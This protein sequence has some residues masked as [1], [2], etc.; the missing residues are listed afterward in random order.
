M[1]LWIKIDTNMLGDER[2]E[3]LIAGHGMKGLGTYLMIRLKMEFLANDQC[4][5]HMLIEACRS[6][7]RRNLLEDIISNYN[8]FFVDENQLVSVNNT[9][10][11]ACV[12]ALVPA[13][14]PMHTPDPV[15]EGAPEGVPAHGSS[16]RHDSIE[17]NR[18]ENSFIKELLHD[19][20][21]QWAETV[22]MQSGYGL[23]LRKYWAQAVEQFNQHVIAYDKLHEVQTTRDTRYYFNSFVKTSVKSGQNLRQYLQQLEND[24]RA[25]DEV[26]QNMVYNFATESFQEI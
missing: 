23:L 16:R 25:S 4:Q 22:C 3:R 19:Q 18:I 13:H 9:G 6:H 1:K 5:K 8:L 20:H 12:P 10:S 26:K 21:T 15:P 7:A 24:S 14:A 2:F 11:Y 17:E